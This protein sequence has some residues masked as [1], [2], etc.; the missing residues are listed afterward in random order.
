[1]SY[2]S[3]NGHEPWVG[4][5]YDAIDLAQSLTPDEEFWHAQG[6]L[7]GDV[8]RWLT[9]ARSLS[10]MGARCCVLALYLNPKLISKSSLEEI[11]RMRGSPGRAALSKAMLE[12]QRRYGLRPAAYQKLLWM[13]ERYRRS[14]IL[15]H[16][17]RAREQ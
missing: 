8:L 9:S 1:M 12:F 11:S 15:A 13:R 10:R 2:H 17:Q 5:D 6:E 14:A 7:F 4:F 16:Q 3:T